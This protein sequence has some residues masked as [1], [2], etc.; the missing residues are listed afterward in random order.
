[1]IAIR[2]IL[3]ILRKD[4][5]AELRTKEI[6]TTMLVFA[7]VVIVIFNFVFDPGSEFIRTSLPG[8]LWVAIVFA[9]NLGLGRSFAREQESGM[10]QGLL[11]CP[12]ERSNIYIAKVTGNVIFIFLVELII[13]PVLIILFDLN[14]AEIWPVLFLILFLGT[15]GFASVGTIFSA[16]S[17]N[18]KSREIMLPILL[19]PVTVP[20]ILA[21]IKGTA[22]LFEGKEMNEVWSWIR[23]LSGFDIVFFVVSYILYE[24]VVEE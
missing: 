1:M 8:I 2:Q 10:M 14:I 20:V 24:Y 15:I 18:T 4:I 22:A 9:S 5:L 7:L 12:V 3:A 6:I 23:I 17:A 16:I 13:L 11:L 21:S 19:F